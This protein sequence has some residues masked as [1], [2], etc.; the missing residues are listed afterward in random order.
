[1]E[2][3]EVAAKFGV[4]V[5]HENVSRYRAATPE[6]I[7]LLRKF[8]NDKLKFTYDIK[9]SIRAGFDPASVYEAMRGS[10]VNV[11]I[12]DNKKDNECMLP[13]EGSFDFAELFKK[14]KNDGYEGSCVIEVYKNAYDSKDELIKAYNFAKQIHKYC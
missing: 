9:Q 10:I 8:T 13:G 3:N 1:M 5:S 2:M 4:T 14:L 7:K 11:H 6:N 12:S